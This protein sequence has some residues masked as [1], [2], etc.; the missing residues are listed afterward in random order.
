MIRSTAS[1]NVFIAEAALH[2]NPDIDPQELFKRSDLNQSSFGFQSSAPQKEVFQYFPPSYFQHEL[3]EDDIPEV[4]I[5]GR[6]NVGKSSL[7]NA[8]IGQK[9][10]LSSK[11]PGRT[12]Q[13][14]YYGWLNNKPSTPQNA[15]QVLSKGRV[16]VKGYIVD[17]PGYG[18][19]K[20]P[21]AAIEEW[22]K[23]SQNFLISRR[24]SGQLQRLFLLID[25]RHGAN[26]LDH[27]VMNWFTEAEIP[28][29]LVLTKSD[30]STRPMVVKHA[31][32]LGMR[33]QQ[34]VELGHENDETSFLSP[35]VH[36][37]S[38]KSQLGL[39]ELM[40]SIET[41][42]STQIDQ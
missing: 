31:N 24:D 20:G 3:P 41:E 9:L 16:P 14:F 17:M 34:E 28:Y 39:H 26:Q 4:A 11:V 27:S 37:T 8:L 12:Q 29:S 22:Q 1:Q 33:Y 40:Y 10:A 42:F 2:V 18:Y 15:G 5:L 35:V 6:S 23:T 13:V 30:A 38:A 32:L 7:I 21:D 19:A 25:A 36:I